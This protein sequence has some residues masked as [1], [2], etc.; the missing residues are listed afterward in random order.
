MKKGRKG[1]AI[2]KKKDQ[3]KSTFRWSDEK[4]R[5]CIIDHKSLYYDGY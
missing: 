2:V 5:Y 3:T 4:C 1:E